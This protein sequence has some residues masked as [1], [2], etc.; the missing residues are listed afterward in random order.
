M[1][2]QMERAMEAAGLDALDA[3]E[4]DLADSPED[5][6]IDAIEDALS[7]DGE[8]QEEQPGNADMVAELKG[9]I[10]AQAKQIEA[11]DAKI[12]RMVGIM[13]KLVTRF[14]ASIGDGQGENVNTSLADDE[15]PDIPNI[16][17]I[18][19]GR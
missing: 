14:G 15:G 17:D 18:Q 4:A 9:I 12:N 11:Q 13:G 7:D 3:I 16:E 1:G 6:T 19:L 8:S 2:N 10:D 5:G